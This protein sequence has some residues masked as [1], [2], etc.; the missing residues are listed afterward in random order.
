MRARIRAG[1]REPEPGAGDAVARHSGAREALEQRL[2]DLVRDARPG[3]LDGD[4]QL[5]VLGRR[6][7]RAPAHART[8]ARS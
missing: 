1:D 6:A 8:E 7:S 5:A 4:A 2:L 3:V